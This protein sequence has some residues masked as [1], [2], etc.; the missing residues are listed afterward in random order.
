[1]AIDLLTWH[2][3]NGGGVI[4]GP[5]GLGIFIGE[6]PNRCPCGWIFVDIKNPPPIEKRQEI[7]DQLRTGRS[8]WPEKIKQND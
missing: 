3:D 5:Q 7:L 2:I 8:R 1:M 6:D 4:A